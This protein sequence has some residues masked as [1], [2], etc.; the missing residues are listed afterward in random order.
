MTQRYYI[1]TPIYY[2]NDTPHI[3]HA[4]EAIAT[5]AIA[6]FE[7]LDGKDVLFLTG[8]DEHG[9]KMKQTAVKE[10]LTP[11]A[12]EQVQQGPGQQQAET[13]A[14]DGD[15]AI[16]LALGFHFLA[17]S[18]GIIFAICFLFELGPNLF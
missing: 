9:L 15:I 12:P 6:R 18:F 11:R 3:G 4:Y 13:H 16:I 14:A 2:V 17:C 1:T 8:T 5:D 7:R 10:G